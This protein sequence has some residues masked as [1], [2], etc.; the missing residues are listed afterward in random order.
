M[1]IPTRFPARTAAALLIL[2]ALPGC[3]NVQWGGTDVQVVPPPPPGGAPQLTPDAQTFA[4]LGLPSGTVLFHV[5][6]T[7]QGATVIPVAEV[8]GDSLRT[9]RR[10]A[11]VAPEAYE[12]RFRNAVLDQGSQ[13]ELFRRG[14]AVGTMTISGNGPVTSCGIPTGAGTLTT[15]GAA[16]DV[17]E[18][19]AFRRG[20]APQALGEYAP[21]QVTG[22]IRTFASIV[23]EKLVLQNGLP[24]PRSWPGAQRDMQALM[25]TKNPNPDMAATYL[26]GDQLQQ[27]P[28]EPEG[29]SIFYIADY[30]TRTGYVPFYTEVRDYRKTGKGAPRVVDYLNWNGRGGTDILVQVY[31]QRESWYEVVSK[32][33]RGKWGRVWEGARCVDKRPAGQ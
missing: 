1:P 31:G 12:T 18:F 21:P 13:F 29:Y 25:V 30:N 16:A 11:G 9:L 33:Q 23:A 26:V 3:D 2:T 17:P 32:D 7:P 27:G 24:R 22:S 14:A 4:D 6:R 10:P 19:L 20:L 8:S 15:V 5:V 28:S